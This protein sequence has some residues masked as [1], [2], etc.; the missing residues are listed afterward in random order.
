M[1]GS[2]KWSNIKRRK[3]AQD[4]RRAR[5][6]SQIS[7]ELMTA[8]REGCGDID[9]SRNL[10]LRL[11]I[12]AAKQGNMPGDR[13]E[14]AIRRAAGLDGAP[15]ESRT[16]E[17]YS[18]DGVGLIIE[19]EADNRNR[20]VGF[21]RS[22]LQRHGGSLGQDG[23]LRFAFAQRGE[24]R[25]PLAEED[26]DAVL[27]ELIDAGVEDGRWV[28]GEL[29]LLSSAEAF[30]AVRDAVR[31]AELLTTSAGLVWRARVRQPLSPGR[32]P[33]LERLVE[34]LLESEDVVQVTHNAQKSCHQVPT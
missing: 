30:A 9:P 2:N 18:S 8:V 17:G 33:S 1:S 11:A 6:F 31:S 4:A 20:V 16:F 22:T 25:V 19:T 34:A 29:V 27:L 5:L 32:W 26:A 21:V 3:G 24:L 14:R 10:R 13:I 12:Q 15:T 23:C 7:R 28:A